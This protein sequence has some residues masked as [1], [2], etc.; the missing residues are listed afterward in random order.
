[1]GTDDLFHKRKARLAESHRREKAKRAPYERILI[2]CE[3]KKTEPYYF[4][5]LCQDLRLNPKNVVIEDKKSGLDPK[6]LVTFAVETFK[7][8]RDFDRVYCVFD[9][10]KHASYNDALEKIRATRLAG[11]GTL[12]AITSVPC[13]EIWLLLHFTYT[14]GPF[15]TAGSDSNCALV[16]D[17]LDRK[18]R[19][20][21]YEKGARD[22]FQA[23]SDKLEK[24]IRNAEKLEDF[25]KTSRTDNP[26]TK[27]HHLVQYLK[28]LKR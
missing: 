16:M 18:G 20:P 26:S 13:F 2:V 24:A 7:K 5:G 11:G 6:S 3:G 15:S 22:I 12:H 17:A 23:I 14:T 25:H 9:K 19:I 21:G 1:M 27:V 28:S 8:G 10:D 4:R